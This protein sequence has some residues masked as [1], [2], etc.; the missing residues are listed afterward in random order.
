LIELLKMQRLKG[1]VEIE[2]GRREEH[3]AEDV[4]VILPVHRVEPGVGDP[5]VQRVAGL[6]QDVHHQP[7]VGRRVERE[8]GLDK[9]NDE[10]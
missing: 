3:E 9:E 10:T 1:L 8:S 4:T 6:A 2:A 5:T 7:K